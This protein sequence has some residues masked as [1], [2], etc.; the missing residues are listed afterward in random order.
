MRS[1]HVRVMNSKQRKRLV[2]CTCIKIHGPGGSL[3]LDCPPLAHSDL[4]TPLSLSSHEIS[5]K[6]NFVKK[7]RV[8]ARAYGD[9]VTLLVKIWSE[10][11]TNFQLETNDHPENCELKKKVFL[12]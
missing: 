2:D 10:V 8:L 3:A 12:P 7:K 4:S 1:R 5:N 6:K 11:H 9:V